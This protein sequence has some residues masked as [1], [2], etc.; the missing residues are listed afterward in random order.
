MLRFITSA[1]LAAV[2][3]LSPLSYAADLGPD[4]I[5]RQVTADVLESVQKDKQLQAGDRRKTLALAEEKILPLIDF[6]QAT[7]LAVG[8]AWRQATPEQRTRL[9]TEFRS[10]LVRIY[11]N[12]L[13]TYKGQTMRVQPVRMAKDATDVT[14]RNQY[15]SPGKPPLAVDYS[16]RKTDG[17][18]KIYDIVTEG[19]SL[20]LTYRGE[21]EQAVQHGGVDGLIK[22]LAEKNAPPRERSS[23]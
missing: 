3:L 17:T 6:D 5:V 1:F 2:I 12:A 11:S 14:V 10:M 23:S 19:I 8:R 4:E 16:M 20:V 21:F 18:W 22:Q 9:V 13:G 7:Q 15:I